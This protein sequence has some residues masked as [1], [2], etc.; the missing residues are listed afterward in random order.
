MALRS[1][2][3]NA[4]LLSS[5]NGNLSHHSPLISITRHDNISRQGPSA[6]SYNK[7]WNCLLHITNC[8][9]GHVKPVLPSRK[10]SRSCLLMCN[11]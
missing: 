7:H 2:N 9:Y 5:T 11:I 3:L 1:I 10:F 4:T 8:I 6:S